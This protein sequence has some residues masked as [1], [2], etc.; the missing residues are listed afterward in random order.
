[1]PVK[2]WAMS[3]LQNSSRLRLITS[4]IVIV[5]AELFGAGSVVARA[6]SSISQGFK[7]GST[8][9]TV[10][11]LVGIKKGE[12]DTV[13]LTSSASS[14]S[15]VGIVGDNPLVELST[16]SNTIQVVTGGVTSAL[17]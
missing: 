16:G 3:I 11:A 5:T 13:E 4:V 6:D 1:M 15:L 17:V 7:S 8:N 9:V 12:P 10:A 2:G 14:D